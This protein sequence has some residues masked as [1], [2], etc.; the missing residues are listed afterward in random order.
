M[1]LNEFL[2]NPKK[3]NKTK[4]FSKMR[5]G[6]VAVLCHIFNI[7]FGLNLFLLNYFTF[8]RNYME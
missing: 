8:E 7:L 3:K 5:S 1:T 6:I 2:K 4:T